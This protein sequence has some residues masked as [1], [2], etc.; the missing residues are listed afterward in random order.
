MKWDKISEN[1]TK[2]KGKF[3]NIIPERSVFPLFC[4]KILLRELRGNAAVYTVICYLSS[5]LK[6]NQSVKKCSDS[7]NVYSRGRKGVMGGGQNPSPPE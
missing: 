1:L 7:F 5:L 2:Y 3:S 4:S 6:L